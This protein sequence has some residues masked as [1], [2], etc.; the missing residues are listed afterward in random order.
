MFSAPMAQAALTVHCMF[1][2]SN[3]ER[4]GR[5]TVH[6]TD[7]RTGNGAFKGTTMEER[8]GWVEAFGAILQKSKAPVVIVQVTPSM[9]KL[10]EKT[11]GVTAP[12]LPVFD[13][14]KPDPTALISVLH[15]LKERFW[16]VSP[17]H[18]DKCVSAMADLWRAKGPDFL[19]LERATGVRRW[20]G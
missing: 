4:T 19:S 7:L 6:F 14:T 16:D 2:P 18:H 1:E 20:T 15:I 9:I 10:M 13:L 17:A 11:N 5:K 12:K 8:L 3:I